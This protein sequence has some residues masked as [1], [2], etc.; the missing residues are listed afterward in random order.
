[1]ADM[2][3][4]EIADFLAEAHVAH[5][6]TVRVNGRPQVAPVWFLEDNG[7]A[8]VMAEANAVKVRNIRRNPAVTLSIA[9]DQRPLKYVVLTGEA[10]VVAT[11]ISQIVER[12]CVRYDGPV[13]GVEYAKKLLSEDRMRLI[14]ILVTR[15]VGWRDEE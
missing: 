2:T 6:V 15:V 13:R 8:F 4:Q 10:Q 7:Q 1:M 14:D 5:L 9:T 3:K 11:D 12:L